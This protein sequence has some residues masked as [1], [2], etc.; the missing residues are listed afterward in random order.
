MFDTKCFCASNEFS[1]RSNISLK[2]S[3]SSD[4]S[5]LLSLFDKRRSRLVAEIFRAFSLMAR[6][7]SNAFLEKKIPATRINKIEII[8]T[9][10]LLFNKLW[11]LL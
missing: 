9:I 10:M 1:K 5:S 8:K 4:S 3:A 7:G 11:S 6:T 2:V